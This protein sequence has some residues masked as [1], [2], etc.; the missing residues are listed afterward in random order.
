[1]GEIPDLATLLV[2]DPDGREW[3]VEATRDRGS[4][5]PWDVSVVRLGGLRPKSRW[6]VPGDFD[7]DA[8]VSRVASLPRAGTDP[9]DLT[10]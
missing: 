3:R 7:I 10:P 5:K 1:M 8:E 4:A 9:S 6:R 2:R